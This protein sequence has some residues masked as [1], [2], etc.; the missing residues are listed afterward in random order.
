MSRA[1]PPLP[2]PDHLRRQAKDLLR[3]WRAG[4]V[5]ALA[6]ASAW[7]LQ[8]PWQ[9]AAAQFVIAREHQQASWPRLM[10]AVDARRATALDEADFVAETVALAL[11]RGWNAPQPARALA[12][13]AAR[14]VSH[15][16]LAL[17][18]GQA[19]EALSL[20]SGTALHA[21][22]PPWQAPPLVYAAAS[23]LA[24]L[25]SH[26]TALE[27]T[28][29]TLLD[30]GADP[31]AT[32]TDPDN[33]GQPLPVLYGAVARSRSLG[34][35]ERLL[36]A[37]ADPND[38]ESLYHAAERD[39]PAFMSAL[40]RAGARWTGT[41][42][43]FRQLDHEHPAG[44][45]AALA[46]GADPNERG[47]GGRRA[48]HHALMRG[49]GADSVRRL[50]DHGADPAAPDDVGFIAADYAVRAGDR[51]SLAL[52]PTPGAAPRTMRDE[53]AFAAACAAADEAQARTLLARDAKLVSRLPPHLLRLLP[54]QA[55]R[56]RHDAVALMLALGWP[57]AVKGD[58]DASALNQAAFRG[59]A[60]MVRLLL[61]HDAHWDERNGYGGNVVGSCLHAACNEPVAGG[62]YAA[63][64]GLLLDAGAPAPE[65][66]DALPSDLQDVINAR[67]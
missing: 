17:L 44:L 48:L 59:D 60:A 7:Q 23:G 38:N 51:A 18:R 58:W 16:A 54:E 50:L 15:P 57:V 32:W 37:G 6:R 43:L 53:E 9:L 14:P 25:D 2:H 29:Q 33:P 40:V 61:A 31:N 5:A 26:R 56:G 24:R 42:A 11:G 1:L 39:D 28:V 10:A 64:L 27:H 12:G 41:N 30:H 52:L 66:L 67:A 55:Q 22:L 62:D 47:P 8:P 36:A 3:A 45:A 19:D 65:D 63:V 35:V 4:D 21:N 49:R 20:L 46:L 34:I 13:L